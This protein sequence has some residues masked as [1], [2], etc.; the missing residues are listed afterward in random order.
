MPAQPFGRNEADLPPLPMDAS[1]WQSIAD[2]LALA[3]QQVRIVELILRGRQDKEIAADLG[4]S[5]PTVRT[6]LGRIFDK[7]ESPDR[8]GLVLQIFARAQELASLHSHQE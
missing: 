7:T 2:E 6:Y 3:P 5:F 1:I 4:I 8:M